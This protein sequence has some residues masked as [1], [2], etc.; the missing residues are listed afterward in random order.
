MTANA[1]AHPDLFRAAARW[2]RDRERCS[3][4][5][6]SAAT[7]YW[8]PY[9]ASRQVS[10]GEWLRTSDTM[11]RRPGQRQPPGPMNDRG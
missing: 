4:A 11:G 8:S 2:R 3:C 5:G 9:A 6:D 7:G 1:A 10:Q